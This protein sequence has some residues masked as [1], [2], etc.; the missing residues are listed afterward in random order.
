M[1]HC[2]ADHN[3]RLS[4]HLSVLIFC[5][6][7]PLLTKIC[8]SDLRFLKVCTTLTSLPPSLS[9]SLSFF[10][11][12]GCLMMW[13]DEMWCGWAWCHVWC[14]V[15][16]VL[17]CGVNTRFVNPMQVAV[18]F[19]AGSANHSKSLFPLAGSIS[20][21][22]SLSHFAFYFLVLRYILKGFS[23]NLV[24]PFVSLSVC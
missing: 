8:I 3:S 24:S 6:C 4:G 19:S 17:E 12:A 13:C 18:P 23:L 7:A 9:L 15:I 1:R 20:L 21:S 22:L 11:Q 16:I 5:C 2:A 10:Y 14:I